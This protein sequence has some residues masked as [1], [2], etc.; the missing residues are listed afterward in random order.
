MSVW[1]LALTGGGLWFWHNHQHS[2][3]QLSEASVSDSG[4]QT[5]ATQ[6]GQQ[7]N[8]ISPVQTP[9]TNPTIPATGS[10]S[11][12]NVAGDSTKSSASDVS[13]L[14]DPKTFAQY[15]K[16]KSDQNAY[17]IELAQGN[18]AALGNNQKAA[19]FYK[20]WLTNGTLFDE[21]KAG[22]DGQ[23]QPFVFTE[24]AHQ[25]IT[26]WEQAL[27][28][29]KVGGVRLVIVPPSVGYGATGQGSIPPN[30]VLVFQV[31]LAAVQ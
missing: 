31:Q 6:S 27:A 22:S 24:G 2:T 26:G 23:L 20:G 8:T 3:N 30:A 9:T 19:V 18:G 14:L 16:Y 11:G 15:D 5:A 7:S 10:G 17:F 29:M 21:S 28:G 1:V 12:G 13:K 4:N 25:V